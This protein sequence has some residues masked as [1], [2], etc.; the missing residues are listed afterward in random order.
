[1]MYQL[2]VL[3]RDQVAGVVEPLEL[4]AVAA[5]AASSCFSAHQSVAGLVVA[6]SVGLVV[7]LAS[8]AQFLP[9]LVSQVIRAVLVPTG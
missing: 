9:N 1:M 5:K 6:V 8:Q 2:M 4:A 7:P 3:F